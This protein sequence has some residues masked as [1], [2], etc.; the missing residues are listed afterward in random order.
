MGLSTFSPGASRTFGGASLKNVSPSISVLGVGSF[1]QCPALVCP[2]IRTLARLLR[3]TRFSVSGVLVFLSLLS[4][5]GAPLKR[6]ST[7]SWSVSGSSLGIVSKCYLWTRAIINVRLTYSFPWPAFTATS[8]LDSSF[9]L[10]FAGKVMSCAILVFRSRSVGSFRWAALNP[11]SFGIGVVPFICS[12][13]SSSSNG[14]GPSETSES[15][16]GKIGPDL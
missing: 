7:R 1:S 15:R 14:S 12:S 8:V 10:D 16:A 6:T 2:L 13:R 9:S 11:S 3:V 5:F 4:S